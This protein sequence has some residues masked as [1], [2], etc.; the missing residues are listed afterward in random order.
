MYT[1]GSHHTSWPKWCMLPLI[2]SRQ[3][4]MERLL[5]HPKMHTAHHRASPHSQEFLRRLQIPSLLFSP[6]LSWVKVADHHLQAIWWP[7]LVYLKDSCS[8]KQTQPEVCG[9]VSTVDM[10]RII[11]CNWTHHRAR[12]GVLMLCSIPSPLE[13]PVCR[14]YPKTLLR[15]LIHHQEVGTRGMAPVGRPSWDQA[16]RRI[17]P[18]R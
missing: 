2:Q 12:Q 4:V 9:C 18:C 1:K 5:S 13:G 7:S 16:K 10:C 14:Y 3:E 15:S 6:T 17:K 8:S 11:C